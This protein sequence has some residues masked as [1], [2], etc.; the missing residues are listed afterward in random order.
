MCGWYLS[1]SIAIRMNVVYGYLY[2]LNVYGYLYLFGDYLNFILAFIIIFYSHQ[3][4]CEENYGKIKV[5]FIPLIV[6]YS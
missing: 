4:L 1:Y 2:F 3:F 5:L 6:L